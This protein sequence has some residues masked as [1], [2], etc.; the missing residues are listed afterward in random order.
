[1][2]RWWLLTLSV[3]FWLLGAS[4]LALLIGR[5]HP[6]AQVI[7]FTINHEHNSEIYVLDIARALAHPIT[8][9]DELTF[10][11]TPLWSPDGSQL[12]YVEF[13]GTRRRLNVMGFICCQGNQTLTSLS[14]SYDEDYNPAWANDGSLLFVSN[15]DRQNE[16]YRYVGGLVQNLT[17]HPAPD[18]EPSPSPDGRYIA[19]VSLRDGNRE[20]YVLDIHCD[21]PPRNL[22]RHFSDDI[23]PVWSPDGQWIAF[24]SDRTWNHDLFVMDVNGGQV[25]N[26]TRSHGEEWFPV[27]S[28]DSQT[29]AFVSD[30][31]G[32]YEVYTADIISGRIR[33]VTNNPAGDI[34]PAWS[35]DG[36]SIAF[37]S[38]RDGVYNIYLASRDGAYVRPITQG[39]FNKSMPSW[40]PIYP[41]VSISSENLSR[42]DTTQLARPTI[43]A[44]PMPTT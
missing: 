39:S 33:N 32:N 27:W 29:I 28:P 44:S 8:R 15:R 42:L 35:P 10:Y 2:T 22:T 18:D 11:S 9:H 20:I 38:F 36:Q 40:K 13:F 1:M 16:I 3:V 41:A 30:R 23:S 7:S 4:G 6:P 21:C 19:F 12:A 24:V 26:L 14:E 5:L 43:E 34:R 37:L 17:Q 31:P 25:R